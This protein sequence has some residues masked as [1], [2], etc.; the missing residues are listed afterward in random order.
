M[1][2]QYRKCRWCRRNSL[3]EIVGLMGLATGLD[4]RQ[5][6]EPTRGLGKQKAP[7][8]PEGQK[9]LEWVASSRRSVEARD[10]F[11]R[12]QPQASNPKKPVAAST[13]LLG[14]GTVIAN[15]VPP[16]GLNEPPCSVTQRRTIQHDPQSGPADKIPCRRAAILM[17]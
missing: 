4:R 14:S 8:G 13:T 11:R 16:S 9:G 5:G 3:L 15:T 10:H 1:L 2:P 12:R 17:H 7:P 6:G